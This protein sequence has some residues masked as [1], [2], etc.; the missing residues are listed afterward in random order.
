VLS[1]LG[2]TM[3][4][5]LLPLWQTI[6]ICL[7][8]PRTY[9]L[10]AF[11]AV[12]PRTDDIVYAECLRTDNAISTESLRTDDA[13]SAEYPRTDNTISAQVSWVRG[14]MRSICQSCFELLEGFLHVVWRVFRFWS[15][16]LLPLSSDC[17]CMYIFFSISLSPVMRRR[18]K[19]LLSPQPVVLPPVILLVTTTLQSLKSWRMIQ[20]VDVSG[21]ESE[22]K[23]LHIWISM[24][25]QLWIYKLV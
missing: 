17:E 19:L 12:F 23:A 10:T 8:S 22:R 15:C 16:L 25:V 11:S 20:W 2:Q 6:C 7:Q 13:I 1:P 4:Y 5:L 24:L 21:G 18:E 14:N 9:R 3:L